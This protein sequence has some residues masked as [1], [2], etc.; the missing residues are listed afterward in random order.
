MSEENVEIARRSVEAF[1]RTLAEGAS[2]YYEFLDEEVEWVPITSFLDGATYRGR[3]KVRKW[4]DDLRRD[5]EIYEVTWDEV[6]D[7]GDD[8]VL[9]LGTWHARGRRS[10]VELGFQQ[11]AWLLHLRNRKLI[12]LQ[13]FTDLN[14][15]LEAAGLRE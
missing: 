6:R 4:I 11:A 7:L 12:R 1:N 8:R 9:A 2:D 10:G 3:G 5:W 13:T 15:A 14:K